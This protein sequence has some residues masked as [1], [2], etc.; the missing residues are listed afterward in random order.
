MVKEDRQEYFMIVLSVAFA[1]FMVRLSTHSVN[2]SLPTIAEHF[3]VGTGQVSRVVMSYLLIITV[4]LLLFG[5]MGDRVGLKKIF[6]W[7][8]VIFV[9]GSLFCGLSQ[10]IH[11]LVGARAVQGLGGSMLM[12]TSFAIIAQFV[13]AHRRGW[14]FG[15]TSTASAVG[16][17][18]GAPLGGLIAH[19]FSWHWIFI[20][21]I[22]VGIA[23][24][25]VAGKKIPATL[26][27][28]GMKEPFDFPGAL[29]SLA[30]LTFL[31]YAIN[32]GEES[33]WASIKVIFFFISS[34]ILLALF[35]V[36]EKRC[37][38]P[39]LD[40]KLFNNPAF[41]F[42]LCATFMSYLLVSGNGF[43]LPFYLKA[44][45]NLNAQQT[46]MV[47]LVYSVV[48]IFMSSY[49]G[50]LSDRVGPRRLC[51]AAMVSASAC[52][53]LF[54]YTLRFSGIDFVLLYLV[55]L[56]FSLVFFFSPN[57]NQ[58]MGCT[59]SEEHG[60]ASGAFNAVINLS[61]VFGVA[62]FEVVFTIFS[63]SVAVGGDIVRL[64]A[65]D[66]TLLTRGFAAVYV[67]GGLVCVGALV[68]SLF[69]GKAGE[70]GRAAGG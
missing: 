65:V 38:A 40:L 32:T 58:V 33:G 56:A 17:A 15:I 1:S 20:M 28:T 52:A 43:T 49:A 14:A 51:M 59:P 45:H 3:N 68:F 67:M 7:G 5:K 16:V 48:F 30:G 19:S 13:P 9:L 12:A 61:M 26:P 31:L 47:L 35:L 69:T 34:V 44:L 46:G 18:T 22:P 53:F 23:A 4:T 50:K 10:D 2:V 37:K 57:N 66:A 62:L 6:L 70:K 29:L 39:L 8:Y 64:T 24:I 54:S 21:N 25:F 11:T 55:W 36:R 27:R 41:S 60:A 42:A 63:R